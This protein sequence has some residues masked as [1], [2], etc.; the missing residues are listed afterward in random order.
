MFCHICG[1]QIAE[2]AAFCHK[3]GT[4]VVYEGIDSQESDIPQGPAPMVTPT[5][6]SV[7][8]T[9]LPVE[10][11]AQPESRQSSVELVVT[12]AKL[13]GALPGSMFPLLVDKVQVGELPN[14]GTFTSRIA[15]G[16]HQIKVGNVAIGINIPESETTVALKLQ[17]GPSKTLEFVCSP[18]H[19]VTVPSSIE[20]VT[21]QDMLRDLNATVVAGLVCVAL[22]IIGFIIAIMI[23]MGYPTLDYVISI[24]VS[25]I[26]LIAA[27]GVFLIL[28]PKTRKLKAKKAVLG[29]VSV[30]AIGAV[31]V[32]VSSTVLFINWS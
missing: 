11:P 22:G 4:K 27:G 24:F 2:G 29:L 5:L 6:K 26:F 14:N 3:C 28:S 20:R 17:L 15:P 13:R 16:P 21:R 23:P 18:G 19:I 31:I 8:T 12:C 10:M 25:A 1:T 7:E 9:M 30:I 32:I